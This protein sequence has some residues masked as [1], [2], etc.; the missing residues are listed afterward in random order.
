MRLERS[1]QSQEI[2]PQILDLRF[3]RQ[4]SAILLLIGLVIHGVTNIN[5]VRRM[6]VKPDRTRTDSQ[7]TWLDDPSAFYQAMQAITETLEAL[8]SP[9]PRRPR[10]ESQDRD[11]LEDA[12]DTATLEHLR[13][14]LAGVATPSR[15]WTKED[16]SPYET[17]ESSINDRLGSAPLKRLRAAISE[18]NQEL[19]RR[20]Q[21]GKAIKL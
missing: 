10:E 20:K 21:A 4:T 16:G 15:H 11:E 8:R 6:L 2:L 17:L 3:G 18:R 9:T 12:F 13:D 14:V 19:S 1:F 7:E 5:R